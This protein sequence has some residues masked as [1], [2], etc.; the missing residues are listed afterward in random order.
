MGH[1]GVWRERA[2]RVGMIAAC[3]FALASWASAF[4]DVAFHGLAPPRP[5]AARQP[6]KPASVAIVH[7][8]GVDIFIRNESTRSKHASGS[9]TSGVAAVAVAIVAPRKTDRIDLR[10]QKPHKVKAPAE[11][12]STPSAKPAQQLPIVPP[13]AATPSLAATEP[14]SATPADSL[15]KEPVDTSLST[16][17]SNSG[18]SGSDQVVQDR[19]RG[20][21]GDHGNQEDRNRQR[22]RDPDCSRQPGGGDRSRGSH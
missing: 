22:D 9:Q 14:S 19:P 21:H 12:P 17:D 3:A 16:P 15:A 7:L 4:P 1:G 6:R 10:S 8:R 2:G 20:R 18:D 11:P 13:A 5:A